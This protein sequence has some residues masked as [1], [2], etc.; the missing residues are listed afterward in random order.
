M[1]LVHQH[2]RRGGRQLA[3]AR[4][5]PERQRIEVR[6]GHLTTAVVVRLGPVQVEQQ[7]AQELVRSQQRVRDID[8]GAIVP[9]RV[10][11]DAADR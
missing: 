4:L 7:V 6:G 8:S 11:Q 3:Q 1:G 2:E 5:A 10:Q 9:V